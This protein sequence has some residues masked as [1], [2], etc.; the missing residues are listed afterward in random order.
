M[1]FGLWRM[2][3]FLQSIM[4]QKFFLQVSKEMNVKME[5]DR[6]HFL[7]KTPSRS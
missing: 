6:E 4:P 2:L 7:T 5:K 1:G 3:S